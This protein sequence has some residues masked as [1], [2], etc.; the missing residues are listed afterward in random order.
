MQVVVTQ[1]LDIFVLIHQFREE[2][3]LEIKDRT[4]VRYRMGMCYRSLVPWLCHKHAATV[5]IKRMP[6]NIE[7]E[8]SFSYKTDTK[9]LTVFGLGGATIG[10]ET[11][12]VKDS[13]KI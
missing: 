4:L 12:K 11:L 13:I 9:G 8:I 7:E 5:R 3:R 10:T 1:K 2:G 6:E